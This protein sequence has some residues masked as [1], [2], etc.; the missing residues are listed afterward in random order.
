[1]KAILTKRLSSHVNFS[2]EHVYRITILSNL[3]EQE[4][5]TFYLDAKNSILAN[6]ELE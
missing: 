3:Q 1:M 2:N 4:N 5:D 6:L